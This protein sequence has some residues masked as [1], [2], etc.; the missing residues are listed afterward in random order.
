[1]R[2]NETT[3]TYFERLAEI[4]PPEE[5]ALYEN[6]ANP[7]MTEEVQQ[8]FLETY[9]YH[10]SILRTSVVPTVIDAGF[11][12]NVIPSEAKAILD[13]RMLPDEDVEGFL[14][15]T[16]RRHR[17]SHAWRSCPRG[18]IARQRHRPR[19]TTRCSRR[20]NRWR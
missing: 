11:R 17:R 4:S 1:M 10:Y 15:A 5:A 7:E 3:E 19:S 18:S 12:R 13:I 8:T 6:V 2:L 9:P 16:R 14:R 20:W